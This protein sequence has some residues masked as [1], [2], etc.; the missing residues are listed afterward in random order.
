ALI[1][2]TAAFAV[3][4]A[5]FVLALVPFGVARADA[6]AYAASLAG[7]G[8]SF[9]AVT[10]LAAQLVERTRAVYGVG[11][12]VLIVAFVFRGVGDVQD[13]ML[14][15]LS[16]LG[17]A[18]ETRP[19]T[20]TR[21][22]PVALSVAFAATLAAAAFAVVDRRDLG[23]GVLAARPGPTHASAATRN[24]FGLAVRMHRNLV[25]AWV[26]VAAL[27]G[28]AFGSMTDAIEGVSADN[29]AL[30]DVIA[31]GSDQSD[32]FLSFVVILIALVAGGF[33]LQSTGRMA[34]E[35][36]DGRL[37]PVLAG[38]IGRRRWL[39]GHVLAICTGSV[40][41]AVVGV[42]AHGVGVA[43]SS[44]VAAEVVRMLGASLA[45][46]PAMLA[47]AGL[48]TALYTVRPSLQPIGWAA[49]AFAAIVATL[50]DTLRMPDWA[51]SISP[52]DWVGRVPVDAAPAWAL[53]CAAFAVCSFA[54]VAS[55]SIHT[56]DIPAR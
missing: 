12:G 11:L 1:W 21:W 27:L 38:A 9:A 2:T 20:D 42:L 48:A 3:T 24:S 53:A 34:E 5:G 19:F 39:L 49:Y 26:L 32:A 52:M 50:G 23:S 25:G 41:V 6:T 54:V 28:G 31:G 43:A 37:E 15:W 7:L 4:A 17:W 35:E 45:Y 14:T 18:E 36:R 33:A 51:M 40:L 13:T 47:I 46:V 29:N 44:G 55:A 56:R 30:K 10:A 22:W 8:L 16:P